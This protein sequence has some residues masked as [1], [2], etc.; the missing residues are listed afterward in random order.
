MGAPRR[1]LTRR[2]YVV[3]TLA[4]LL[5]V[6]AVVA[7]AAALV[8]YDEDADRHM[9]LLDDLMARAEGAPDDLTDEIDAAADAERSSRLWLL[10][11]ATGAVALGGLVLWS[12]AVAMRRLV[13]SPLHRLATD[14]A[15]VAGGDFAHPIRGERSRE[16]EEL[17][18]SVDRMRSRILNERDHA[19]RAIDA[20]DQQAPALAAL[21]TLLNPREDGG[22]AGIDVAGALV[23]ADGVLAGDWYDIVARPNGVVVALGDICGHGV[24]AGLLAVRTKFALLDAI[25]LGLHPAAALE[26]A[27]SRFGTTE[28]FATAVVAEID[29]QAGV[30]RYASAGHTPILLM[31]RTGEVEELPR[32]GPLLGMAEGPRP[33]ASVPVHPGDT[34]ILY[35][36]GV[37]EAR[38][39]G[40]EQFRID[41]LLELARD[42]QPADPARF[43]QTVLEAVVDHCGGRC[44]DDATIAVIDLVETSARQVPRPADDAADRVGAD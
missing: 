13:V 24:D 28:T 5:L 16:L 34:I 11:A 31:R 21:R 2:F 27:S 19:Q 41:R 40:G 15:E 35:T 42:R 37:I 1:S 9:A 18:D 44:P 12:S 43:S 22:P 7:V 23:P 36:D 17:A 38:P 32:T 3:V 6:G 25:Q 26:L 33:N 8:R 20:M 39:V 10:R 30:C 14:V 4:A 29:L